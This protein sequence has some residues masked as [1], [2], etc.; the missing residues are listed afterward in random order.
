M[1]TSEAYDKVETPEDTLEAENGGQS[2]SQDEVEKLLEMEELGYSAED[3]AKALGRSKNSVY[4]KRW[5]IKGQ[6]SSL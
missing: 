3:I 2:W 4:N 1:F 5:A 6:G